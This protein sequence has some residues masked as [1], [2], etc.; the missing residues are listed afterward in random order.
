LETVYSLSG[1]VPAD[2]GPVVGDESLLR[3]GALARGSVRNA[4]SVR[5]ISAGGAILHCEDMV[6]PGERLELELMSGERLAGTVAWRSGMEIGLS[7]DSRIDVFAIIAQDIVSQPGERRRMPRVE[8]VC[9]VLLETASG[10]ELVTSR[11]VSQGGIKIDVPRRL[12]P[13]ERVSVTLEDFRPLEGVVRWS[14]DS[15]AG[16]AF[17]PELRWQELMLWLKGRRKQAFEAASAPLA[18]AAQPAPP[19]DAAAL[20]EGGLRLNMPARVREGT[21]RWSIEVAW[22][23]TRAVAF[24]SFA[25]LRIGSSLWIALPGLEG[26]PARIISADGYR[27]T[28]EFTQPLHPA[29]LERIMTLAK[30]GS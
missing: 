7:F 26:W 25:A 1:E 18:P 9:P 14:S 22:I 11:D 20:E 15:V 8:T 13:D 3:P 16:I 29:V 4:C 23:T 6:D 19:A 2:A 10:T 12:V 28:C 17:L 24:D 30:T 21:R 5:K 27:F